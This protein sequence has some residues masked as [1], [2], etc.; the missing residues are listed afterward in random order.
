MTAWWLWNFK[1]AISRGVLTFEEGLWKRTLPSQKDIGEA[2]V[3]V[4]LGSH[5]APLQQL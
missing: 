1:W 3:P 5:G 4:Q 2:L